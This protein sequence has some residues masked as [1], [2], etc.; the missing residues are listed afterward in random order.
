M[1]ERQQFGFQF[2]QPHESP[3]KP[4]DDETPWHMLVLGDFSGRGN[5]GAFESP[6]A[7]ASRPILQID[8]DNFDERLERLA[9]QLVLPLGASGA[10][11]TV[12][13]SS[14][15]DFHP[16]RLFDQLEVFA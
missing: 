4:V 14:L 16:D 6:A 8:V 13:F 15:D 9:P 10:A 3:A 1:P 2:G 7:L 5:R 11:M 12:R